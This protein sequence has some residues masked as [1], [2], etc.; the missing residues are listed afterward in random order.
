[1]FK[2]VFSTDEPERPIDPPEEVELFEEDPT[3]GNIEYKLKNVSVIVDEDGYFDFKDPSCPWVD[4]INCY[5]DTVYGDIEVTDFDEIIELTIDLIH[6]EVP[7]EPGEYEISCGITLV[8]KITG[9]L[10]DSDSYSEDVEYFIDD[11]ESAID[12]DSSIVYDFKAFP[13]L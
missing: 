10:S 12:M 3:I 6:D 5:A 13:V 8:F 9:V 1:M 2:Y 4:K 11:S 7:K